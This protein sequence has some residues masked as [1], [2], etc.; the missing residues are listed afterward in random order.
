MAYKI[1]RDMSELHQTGR[2]ITAVLDSASDLQ[3]LIAAEGELAPGSTAVVAAKGRPTYI[4]NASG[5][6]ADAGSSSGGG[7]GEANLGELSLTLVPGDAGWVEVDEAEYPGIDGWN[8]VNYEVA[9]PMT[10]SLSVT[11]NGTYNP[12]GGY[13][14]FDQV[15]VAV[16]RTQ[17]YVRAT[18]STTTLTNPLSNAAVVPLIAE[19]Q[20]VAD[21]IRVDGL[22]NTLLL[23]I[24]PIAGLMVLTFQGMGQQTVPL[25]AHSN[26]GALFVTGGASDSTNSTAVYFEATVSSSDMLEFTKLVLVQNGVEQDVTAMAGQLVSNVTLGLYLN[27]TLLS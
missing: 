23:Y 25:A 1:I 3:A 22:A 8:K 20:Y 27:T 15:V 7:G 17:Q 13:D 2:E 4:L 14:G 24:Q 26:A 9:S 11:E 5:Q 18:V 19:T 21:A 6:W 12:A 10:D 16:P